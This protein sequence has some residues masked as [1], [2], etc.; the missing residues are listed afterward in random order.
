MDSFRRFTLFDEFTIISAKSSSIAQYQLTYCTSC[1][2]ILQSFFVSLLPSSNILFCLPFL[3]L[4]ISFLFYV[5]ECAVQCIPCH[6]KGPIIFL[7]GLLSFSFFMW[8][9]KGRFKFYLERNGSKLKNSAFFVWI[10]LLPSQSNNHVLV[11]M[12]FTLKFGF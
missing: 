1:R 9:Y 3:L 5:Y 8:E 11:S 7:K 10:C 12:V 4:L 2:C 6:K